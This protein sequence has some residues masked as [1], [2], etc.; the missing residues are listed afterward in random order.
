MSSGL[1]LLCPKAPRSWAWEE[2]QGDTQENTARPSSALRR[3]PPTPACFHTLPSRGRQ[4]QEL[5]SQAW[6][7]EGDE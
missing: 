3:H 2:P 6:V 1:Y 4:P 7:F 5:S